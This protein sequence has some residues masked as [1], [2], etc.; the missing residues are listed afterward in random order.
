MGKLKGKFIIAKWNGV[1]R[2]VV[3]AGFADNNMVIVMSSLEGYNTL[4]KHVSLEH[5]DWLNTDPTITAARR[6]SN[7]VGS[8]I[9]SQFPTAYLGMF[10]VSV[11]NG[12]M[13]LSFT[14]C[15]QGMMVSYETQQNELSLTYII[16]RQNI[17]KMYY[18]GKQFCIGLVTG[19][20]ISFAKKYT[21]KAMPALNEMKR[22]LG[23]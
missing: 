16:D 6:P 1:V 4:G 2:D 23:K 5:G 13:A 19:E 20:I 17:T 15:K 18:E 14:P 10:A 9:L 8:S 3:N 11:S 12:G 7:P 21:K 22:L